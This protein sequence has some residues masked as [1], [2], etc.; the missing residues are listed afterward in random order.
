MRDD[1]TAF[2]FHPL[3]VADY[4]TFACPD[5]INLICAGAL[6]DI[7]EDTQTSY[8]ELEHAFNT[9]IASLVREVTK[10]KPDKN[11]AA[12]FPNLKTRRGILLKFFDRA[13]NLSDL[14]GWDDKKI[15]WYLKSSKFWKS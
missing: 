12:T 4:L 3:R 8:D 6:H 11:K 5:D 13:D 1:G 2:V 7:L 15:K 10:Y 14:K 9:D